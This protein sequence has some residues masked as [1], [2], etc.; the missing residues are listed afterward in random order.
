MLLPSLFRNDDFD[1]FFD[2]PFS[3][4]EN[5][6]MMKTDIV[7]KDK[8][9]ELMM[10]MPGVKKEN[11][12][13]ELNDG[14]L[15]VSV[16]NEQ[17]NDEKDKDGRYIRRE[18][19]FGSYSRSFYVGKDITQ[20]DIKAKFENGVLKLDIPKKDELPENKT[21]KFIAIE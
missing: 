8:G 18:R 7:E 4:R 13:A 9:Y 20:E 16:N 14:Y 21:S 10:D 5:P 15:T 17:N 11:V 19:Y 6:S 3:G 1:N 2:M 12:K